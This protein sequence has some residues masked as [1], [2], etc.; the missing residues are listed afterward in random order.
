MVFFGLAGPNAKAR[1]QLISV[2]WKLTF[3]FVQYVVAIT[4]LLVE[5]TYGPR[6]DRGEHEL[7]VDATW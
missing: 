1:S 6:R 7:R 2:A 4:L 3:G 5:V